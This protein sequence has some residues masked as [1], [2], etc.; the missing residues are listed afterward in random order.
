MAARS[1]D[2]IR[3]AKTNCQSFVG[4]FCRRWQRKLRVQGARATALHLHASW[5]VAAAA[6]EPPL[7][8]IVPEFAGGRQGA[9]RDVE[10]A[11]ARR[12]RGPPRGPTR[13]KANLAIFLL[14]NIV[15]MI[16]HFDVFCFYEFG[17]TLISGVRSLTLRVI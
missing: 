9:P 11:A 5:V 3:R 10:S 2:N 12:A 17:R 8:P 15:F 13:V 1:L 7:P 6:A 16:C 4:T 14:D